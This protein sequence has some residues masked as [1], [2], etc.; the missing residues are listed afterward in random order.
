MAFT[1]S[2]GRRHFPTHR[3]A[4]VCDTLDELDASLARQVADPAVPD[5]SSL[6]ERAA[7]PD[8]PTVTLLLPGQVDAR[9]TLTEPS[10][11]A[12]IRALAGSEPSFQL[13]MKEC[14][15]LIQTHTDACPETLAALCTGKAEGLPPTPPGSG[16]LT[17]L[18][19]RVR[20]W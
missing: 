15:A 3:V 19:A 6:G 18:R 16:S 14:V 7:R 8:K 12:A 4:V 20:W 13:A 9:W 17:C 1:L 11:V 2:H 5:A 10:T